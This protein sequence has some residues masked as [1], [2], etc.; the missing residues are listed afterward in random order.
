MGHCF[1]EQH[2][3]RPNSPNECSLTLVRKVTGRIS[4]FIVTGDMG[5]WISTPCRDLSPPMPPN[6]LLDF[7]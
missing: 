2:V 3:L 7:L 5:L 4:W 6:H 1:D